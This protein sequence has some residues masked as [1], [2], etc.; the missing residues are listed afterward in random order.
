MFMKK[1]ITLILIL[2]TFSTVFAQNSGSLKGKLI[3]TIGKQILK[4][5]SIALLD[6]KDSTYETGTIAKVDG[7]FELKS[8]S[9]GN[10]I[11]QVTFQGYEP[12]RKRVSLSKE[13]ASID[14]GTIYMRTQANDLGNVTVTVSPIVI[15]NDTVEYNAGSFKTKP[16]ATAEDLLKKLPG[17]EVSKDGTIKAQGEQVQR[18]L[19]DGKRFFGDDPKTA[20]KNLPTDIIDKVQVYDAQSDQSAF[21]GFDDGNKTKTINIITKKDRR[22]GYFGKLSVAGG[23]DERYE[24]S[25][26]FNRFNGNQ[27]ISVLAQGNN[28]N[29]QGFS[30]QD[31][32]GTMN[33]GGGGRGGGGN[34]GGGG[35]GMGFIQN[36]LGGNT[37]GISTTWAGG[38]NFNDVFSKKTTFNGSFFYNSLNVNR[39]QKSLTE[40]FNQGDSST[41]NNQNKISRNKNNNY[42]F[43]FNIEHQ[44]DSANSLILRP[45]LNYQK[46]NSYSNTYTSTTKGKVTNQNNIN[47]QVNSANDGISGTFDATFRHRFKKKGRTVSINVNFKDNTN[48]GDGDN[49]SL[50]NYFVPF[51]KAD[52]TNQLSN[53]VSDG[54]TISTNLSYT[55]P[56]AKGQLLELSY[57]HADTK[58]FSDRKTLNYNNATAAYDKLDTTQTNNFENVNLNDRVNLAWRLQKQKFNISLGSGIQFT[59][60][61]SNNKTKN[62]YL[63]NNFTNFYPTANFTYNFSRAKSLRVNYSGRTNQPSL[64]Q[65]QDVI[66]NTDKLNIKNGNPAL[67]QEFTNNIRLSYN[68]FDMFTFKNFFTFV[69]FST[70]SNKIVN[71]NYR[72]TTNLPTIIDGQIIAPGV[73]YTKPTNLSGAYNLIS[74]FNYGFPLK[75]PKSNLNFTTNIA[76]S[77]DVSLVNSVKNNTDNLVLGETV[78]WTMNLKN[79]FDLNFSAT[80]TYT[81]AKYSLQTTG[82]S[83]TNY[84]SQT[85]SVEPT[86]STKSGWIFG[87]DFDY[88]FYSGYSA[89]YNTQIPLWNASIAKSI[90]KKKDAEI[91]LSLYDVLNQNVS[92]NRTVTDNSVSDVQTTILQRY[93]LLTFTWN[94][95]KFA[96]KGQQQMP[97]F[98]KGMFRRDG[99]PRM[100]MPGGG[101]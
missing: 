99:Q 15:K 13:N 7:S 97:P 55:E 38:L 17:L 68:T 24:N 63:S 12:V 90:F 91:K 96:G 65:L 89:G 74:F 26:N 36:F 92:I 88:T 47:Q 11:L 73:Q 66:D 85:F 101:F 48:H 52:T 70:T 33:M 5:A 29:R 86:Y 80:S 43:N 64:S 83:N 21:T 45:N 14:F 10:Y 32:L 40:Y 41:L 72:N 100:R 4:D 54:T 62:T 1:I 84:F 79:K 67:K 42:R 35:G 76:L 16:N 56:I 57:Y 94:F 31:I 77:R 19:V 53:S 49:Y 23:T 46:S 81:S 60:L 34:M 95:R 28:V 69:N 25:A 50:N 27:Q 6:A 18:V 75:K 8:V 3:D 82:N 59:H 22:K 78:G 30:I 20:T 39:D 9:F 51:Y 93:V 61:T 58:N 87:S 2:I 98:M 44:F 71:A 37:G